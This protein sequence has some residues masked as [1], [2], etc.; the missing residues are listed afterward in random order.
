[1][2]NDS[3]DNYQIHDQNTHRLV[4][5]PVTAI[6]LGII[7]G[8]NDTK[9]VVGTVVI[10]LL[11]VIPK[12]EDV[13][14]M[15]VGRPLLLKSSE[16]PLP[17]ETTLIQPGTLLSVSNTASETYFYEVISVNRKEQSSKPLHSIFQATEQTVY[18]FA[19]KRHGDMVPRL[20]CLH[21]RKSPF[22]HPD[23]TKLVQS[24]EYANSPYAV[25]HLVHHLIGTEYMHHARTVVQEAANY[26]GRRCIWVP[27]LAAFGSVQ[28][29][30]QQQNT[31]SSSTVTVGGVIDKLAGL[32]AAID[33]ALTHAPSILL[34]EDIDREFTS[35][36]SR[37]DL[38][39][40][41]W[42]ALNEKLL[43]PQ[44]ENI[45]QLPFQVPAV[46]VVL[47]TTRPLIKGALLQNLTWPSIP[48]S[49]PNEEYIR[50]LW[51]GDSRK[52]DDEFNL[53]EEILLKIM[54]GRPAQE[55]VQLL[56][57]LRHEKQFATETGGSDLDRLE[58]ISHRLDE[59]R[60]QQSGS[61]RIPAVRWADIGGL[62]HVRK[63]ILDA[64]DLPMKFPH[65]FGGSHS[66][67]GRSGILLYGPPGT[68]K[69]L[70]AKVRRAYCLF[71]QM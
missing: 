9:I 2:L 45:S 64:I 63:E 17:P 26:S 13:V 54:K 1:V 24:W 65:L 4:V 25:S 22:P 8:A 60:R 71:V 5:S 34:I 53:P 35:E 40:R 59:R 3:G 31:S 32:H 12:A 47:T 50:H 7:I 20:P 69:T 49:P 70:V 44:S 19:N 11:P 61:G 10:Q 46:L 67:K 62:A 57:E 43:L 30:Q 38:E 36:E 48:L 37:I 56:R 58:R 42:M 27:G 51:N 21:A 23:L 52:S 29:Q 68:G 39:R 6:N 15:P 16:F 18:R 41:I 14:L 66:T 28:Q 33:T 55:I